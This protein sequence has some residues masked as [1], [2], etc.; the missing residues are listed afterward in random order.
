M[1]LSERLY[2]SVSVVLMKLNCVS[3]ASMTLN[4]TSLGRNISQKMKA[5]R[6][7]I[8]KAM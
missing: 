6:N 1:M 8:K 2:W 3:E 4:L 5:A 7:N